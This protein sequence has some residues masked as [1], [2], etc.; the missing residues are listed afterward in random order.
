M[1]RE[2]AH[3][4]APVAGAAGFIDALRGAGWTIG[5]FSCDRFT[6]RPEIVRAAMDHHRGHGGDEGLRPLRPLRGETIL[7]GDG[8][9]DIAAAGEGARRLIA[10]GA[11][12]VF[13]DFRERERIFD[14]MLRSAL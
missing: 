10:A 1:L 7:F 4:I 9:W 12:R 6:S 3:E 11:R 2:R 13:P 5:V 8:T 14:A